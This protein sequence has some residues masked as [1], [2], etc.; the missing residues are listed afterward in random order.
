M[1][2]QIIPFSRIK[3]ID[4]INVKGGISAADTMK[5]YNPD[6]LI[7]LALYDTTSGENITKLVD[8]NKAS[9]YL[10]SDEGIGLMGG[11][12]TWTTF[13][14]A[15]KNN[16]IADYVSGSPTLIKNGK[17]NIDWG[18]RYSSYVDGTHLR[19]A[20]G[21]N[22]NSLILLATDGVTSLDKLAETCIDLGATHMINCDGGGSCHLQ[23][24]NKVYRRSYRR[25]CSW[26]L[27]YTLEDDEVKVKVDG[28]EYV[29]TAIVKDGR[30]YV[31]L[32]E[33]EQAGYAIGYTN[34]VAS[35]DKPSK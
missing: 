26:L 1:A 14:E 31:Q 28:K 17:K 10:F 27:V 4:I 25:N 22:D 34:G 3:K 35:I 6:Y 19:T 30:T 5:K 18:N 29:F 9:G 8:N 33:F 24:E 20:V 23:K 32:R 16:A 15:K 21:F 12:P 2:S 13:E 7:N 11:F